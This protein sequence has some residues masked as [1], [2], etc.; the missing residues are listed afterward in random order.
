MEE[1]IAREGLTVQYVYASPDAGTR[2]FAY[3]IGLHT[4]PDRNYELAVSGLN[5]R[6]SGVLLTTVADILTT[7]PVEG[8]EIAGVL[9]DGYKL[10]L[11][12]A[13]RPHRLAIIQA[14]YDHIPSVWQVLWPDREHVFPDDENGHLVTE[15][16]PLL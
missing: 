12:R 7:D 5:D 3:T 4:H 1:I 8:L 14:L 11:R 13:S 9:P 2:P 6:P 16:Q 10:R 15:A